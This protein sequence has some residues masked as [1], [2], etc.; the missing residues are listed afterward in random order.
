VCGRVGQPIDDLQLLDYRAGPPVI[1]DE[2]QRILVLGPDMDE[3]DVQPVDLR[4]EMRKV[5]Q[6]R[7]ASAPVVVR[8]PVEREILHHPERHTL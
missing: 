6:H 4:Q 5:V 2:R 3:V 8:R 7:L 1:N